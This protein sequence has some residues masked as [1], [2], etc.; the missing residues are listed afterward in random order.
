MHELPP[1]G[2]SIVLCVY[3]FHRGPSFVRMLAPRGR[4]HRHFGGKIMLAIGPSTCCYT[5]G[6]P[7]ATHVHH[8]VSKIML[9]HRYGEPTSEKGSPR[10]NK[11]RKHDLQRVVAVH[12]PISQIGPLNLPISPN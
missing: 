11:K 2:F 12:L 6:V 1:F 8:Q 3:L 10:W 5:S 4:G 9:W 7:L